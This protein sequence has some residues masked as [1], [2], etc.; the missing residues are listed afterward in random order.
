MN[1]VENLTILQRRLLR[2]VCATQTLGVLAGLLLGLTACSGGS[3]AVGYSAVG[4]APAIGGGAG[5]AAG[6]SAGLAAGASAGESGS[7]A[8]GSAGSA[9]MAG[10]SAAGGA[11]G[12]GGEAE[13]TC[14][15]KSV[16]SG[17]HEGISLQV[18]DLKR[19][20]DV[21]IPSGLDATKAVPVVLVHHGAGMNG[22]AMRDLTGFDE[23]AEQEGFIAVFPDGA[24]SLWDPG[25]FLLCG[26][27]TLAPVRVDDH[28]FMAA[29]IDHLD[30]EYCIDREAV[31]TTGLSMGGYFVNHTGCK[32]PDLVRAIAPASAGGPPDDCVEGPMPALI[33][34]GTLDAVILPLC[35]REARDKWVEHN[36]C[37]EDSDVVSVK[38]G[39]C[40]WSKDCPPDGQVVYCEFDG[41]IHGWAGRPGAMPFGGEENYEDATSLVWEFFKSQL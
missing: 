12:A 7:D 28:A 38:G 3:N 17:L 4:G 30:E 9:G 15:P 20:F 19:T 35:G 6:G 41:M 22:K 36:G 8:G 34:H 18:G 5:K 11:A 24:V 27:G 25:G 26:L 10:S 13:K 21:F 37:S 16:E 40:E 31:F 33:M 23:L 29:L 39:T 32:R 14:E 1:S 2:G